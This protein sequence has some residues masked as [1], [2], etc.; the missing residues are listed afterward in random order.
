MTDTTN[1]AEVIRKALSNWVGVGPNPALDEAMA[2]LAALTGELEE[3]NRVLWQTVEERDRAYAKVDAQAERI[4]ALEG[5]LTIA[6][7]AE[8]ESLK[9]QIAQAP[10]VEG[11]GID[12][13]TGTPILVYENCSVIQDEQARL[14][15]RALEGVAQARAEEDAGEDL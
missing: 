9:A 12:M 10:S 5:A 4:K 1:H 2:S 8:A 15:L 7:D 13:S 3:A 14:V 6:K 11:W